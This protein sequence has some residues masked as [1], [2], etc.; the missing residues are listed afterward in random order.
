VRSRLRTVPALVGALLAAVAL[1]VAVAGATVALT[2]DD[3]ANELVTTMATLESRLLSQ[4]LLVERRGTAD[5]A[6]FPAMTRAFGVA[7]ADGLANAPAGSTERAR[8]LAQ[9]RLADRWRGEAIQALASPESDRPS[10]VAD[11]QQLLDRFGRE[12]AA[13]RR[14]LVSVHEAAEQRTRNAILLVAIVLPGLAA[15][16]GGF[17]LT[18]HWR[19]RSSGAARNHRLLEEDRRHRVQ[20]DEFTRALQGA[21]SEREA[22]RMLKRQLER[23]MADSS[24]TVLNRNNSDNRLEAV[25]SMRADSPL[26]EAIPDAEPED[27]L[28]VRFGQP[29]ER[30][31]GSSPLLLC[32]LCG[33][34]AGSVTCVPSLVGGKVIGSVLVET[35]APLDEGGHRRLAD[36]VTQAAPVLASMRNLRLAENRAA[37]DLLTG[38]PNRR[39][40]EETLKLMLANAD[41]SATQLAVALFDLDHFKKVNDVFG[42]EKG[43]QLL[44]AVGDVAA[45][46]TRASDFVARFGGEEFLLLMTNTDLPGAILACDKLRE[47]IAGLHV[48]G[49]GHSPSA[50]IGVAVFPE[51]GGDAETLVRGADR[52]LYA[53]KSSGRNCVKALRMLDAENGSSAAAIAL[54][55]EVVE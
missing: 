27:C 43:D 53:A 37:T 32:E 12:G 49:A 2:T 47:A 20:Q 25:T 23:G 14:D 24:A 29:Q 22:Q 21:R 33:G 11:R 15:L 51:D 9:A 1:V 40:A 6:R 31:A 18:L 46:A 17:A 13:F 28:A 45:S 52:A 4:A 10:A 3:D 34:L 42:H 26:A 8:L 5:A 50:S 30:A 7:L 19:R 36:A 16:G 41:R 48:L 39:S 35:P 55:V 44:A 54:P 38:L